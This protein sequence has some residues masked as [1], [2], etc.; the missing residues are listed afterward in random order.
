[1]SFSIFYWQEYKFRFE[2]KITTAT[3]TTT[4]TKQKT[5]QKTP[6]LDQDV[7]GL[8][9]CYHFDG[10]C[11]KMDNNDSQFNVSL[12]VRDS[13]KTVS[14]NHNRWRERRAEAGNRTEVRLFTSLTAGPIRLTVIHPEQQA[15]C[16][17]QPLV[18][19]SPSHVTAERL[20][21][22]QGDCLFTGF[23][24]S[25]SLYLDASRCTRDGLMGAVGGYIG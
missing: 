11:V 23:A 13:H 25:I 5:K 21:F 6:Q 12:I 24:D 18:I 22:P 15:P 17:C 3:I 8:P 16:L 9:Q 19:T 2:F 1:M 20:R 7:L 4:T 10:S 14:T